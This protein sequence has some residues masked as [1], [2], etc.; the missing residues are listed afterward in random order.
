MWNNIILRI[1]SFAALL[2]M[3]AAMPF[4]LTGISI[5]VLSFYFKR[6]VEAIFIG[7]LIDVAYGRPLFHITFIVTLS[8]LLV[9]FVAERIK[10][11]LFV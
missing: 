6:Y 8:C 5:I 9:V 10:R 11:E 2:V 4:W 7:L 1:V 3:A